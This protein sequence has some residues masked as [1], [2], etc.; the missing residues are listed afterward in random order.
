MFAIGIALL[1]Y[2]SYP[3]S[4]ITFASSAF[5][6]IAAISELIHQTKDGIERFSQ[7]MDPD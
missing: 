3:E 6:I 5:I 1:A 2:E 7:M 4:W